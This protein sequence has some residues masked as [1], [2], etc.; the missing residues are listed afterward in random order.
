MKKTLCLLLTL[1]L[2]CGCSTA[3]EGTQSES[4][5]TT[6]ASSD[7]AESS[8]PEFTQDD[9]VLFAMDN[10]SESTYP[11]VW[12]G[13][14]KDMEDDNA[15]A[16]P[17]YFE[18]INDISYNLQPVWDDEGNDTGERVEYIS[19]ISYLGSRDYL[20][21]IKGIRTSGLYDTASKP[22]STADEVIE[23]Y[24]L[25]PDNESIYLGSPEDDNYTIVLYFD[26]DNH[27]NV[28]RIVSPSDTDLSNIEDIQADY[29][30]K[31]MITDGEV[32]GIQMYR[33][34]PVDA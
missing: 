6:T 4:G 1:V 13:M 12:L 24:G 16:Y 7:T 30:L 10:S 26:I 5:T 34:R 8:E 33:K 27:N 32:S 20:E 25:D 15:A 11:V 22:N 3:E 31:F 18:G 23:A 29:F 19:L 17:E 28:M 21:T 14:T 9:F 2:L